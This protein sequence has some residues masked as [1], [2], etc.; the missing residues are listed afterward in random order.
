MRVLATSP[1]RIFS[2]RLALAVLGILGSLAI[3]WGP[4][5]ALVQETLGQE[6]P[7]QESDPIQKLSLWTRTKGSD[8][9]RMLGVHYDSK[10]SETGILTQWPKE[11]LRIVWHEKIG[12]GYGN[13][14]A[15]LGRWLQ[16]D[17]HGNVERLSCYEA[18]T[19]KFLW[20]WE[21]S[22]V[23]Q[24]AY[25][26]N[27]GPRSS[28]IVDGRY[29]YVYGVAGRIACVDIETGKELWQRN[30]STDYSVVPNF[31][32]VGA[33]P[34]VYNDLLIAMVGGSPKR[35]FFSRSATIN[36]M[37]SAK[38]DGTGMIAL[39]KRTGKEVYRV[40][41]Y[42][43][44]YSAPI[45]AKLHGE[46]YCVSL[47]REGLLIFRAKDGTG[48]QFFPFRAATLESVNAASPVVHDNKI[49][50]SEAYEIGSAMLEFTGSELKLLWRDEGMRSSQSM[51]THWT[52]P[53]LHEN[54][55]YASSG[56]N[57]TD[58]DIRCIELQ[59]NQPP[60]TVWSQRNRDRGTG[61]IVDS[62]WLWLGEN[63][64]LHLLKLGSDTHEVVAEMDLQLKPQPGSKE[65]IL[66]P[67]SWAPPVLSH[68]LLFVRG[69]DRIIC[70]ELIPESN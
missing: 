60:K 38:P 67:P 14:V 63:G 61:M 4:Q 30:L 55:L 16:F 47:M 28:P 12:T 62:H 48:E 27:D 56:R 8:W 7:S 64:K 53:L 31:F 57:P 6:T 40:G 51:R 68:G 13:G 44:S 52:T 2:P 5:N 11:G 3:S 1:I 54:R 37:P 24:D 69:S 50:I 70:L 9:P 20:K 43:A 18:Q 39:D 21:A 26:Y 66:N 19:G 15:A 42:L 10:N 36:D 17:R 23:Y 41:N 49:F 32:G 34:L 29:V 65:P 33:S 59:G 46:D 25:G 58:T 22:V 45:I 35:G